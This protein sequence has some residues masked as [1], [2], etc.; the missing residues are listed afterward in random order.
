MGNA[1]GFTAGVF[2]LV[3]RIVEQF[4]VCFDVDV[5]PCGMGCEIQLTKY[6]G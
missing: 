1:L 4:G 6:A 3:A 2:K 5:S